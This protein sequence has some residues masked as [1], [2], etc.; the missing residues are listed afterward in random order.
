MN[1][2]RLPDMLPDLNAYGVTSEDLR[3]SAAIGEASRAAQTMMGGRQIHSSLVT[4]TFDGDGCGK[5]YVGD[6]LSITTLKF[7]LD[8][9]RTY[10]ETLATTDYHLWPN[11]PES[12]RGYRRI[13]IDSYG[14]YSTFPVGRRCIQIVGKFGMTEIQQAVII[15]GAQI[16]GTL[17][18]ASDLTLVT[19]T[20][21]VNNEIAVGDT[22]F[23]GTEEMGPV[24]SV[25][26]TTVT[27]QARGINGTTAATQTTIA[28]S[29]RR[30][31]EDIERAVRADAA[32]YLWRASQGMPE[33]SFTETW[34]A[35]RGTLL[36]YMDA[37][38]VI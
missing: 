2:A 7:D 4:R 36:S 34:G 14:D 20:A 6:I 37:A 26:G 28:I 8:G 17:S 21:I 11:N 38:A 24:V 16:T 3:V 12:G 33:Q 10:E 18:S 29:L 23:M 13:D 5:L 25:S 15:G 19:S 27:L 30:Y 9:D 35:I 31:P 22:L 32:R 1:Y